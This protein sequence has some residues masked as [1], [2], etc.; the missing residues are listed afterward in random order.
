[1]IKPINGFVNNPNKRHERTG[2]LVLSM[3]RC[4]DTIRYDTIIWMPLTYDIR[5]TRSTK[6]SKNSRV[7]FLVFPAISVA[8]KANIVTFIMIIYLIV[9]YMF[10][11]LNLNLLALAI[12]V[13]VDHK[14]EF[15]PLS[16]FSCCNFLGPSVGFWFSLGLSFLV[17][18][19]SVF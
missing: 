5:L 6:R 18:S 15:S 1:M 4:Y 8:T 3:I 10:L 9:K 12:L 13:L 19:S 17:Y 11:N 14:S 7:L 2:H 16:Y